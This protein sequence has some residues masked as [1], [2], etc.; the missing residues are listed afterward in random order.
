MRSIPDDM[1]PSAVAAIDARLDTLV[2]DQFISLPWA[3]ESGS[4]AWGFP[5]PDSDFDCRFVYVR[6]L[7]DYLAL[8]PKRDVI[9][10]LLT[11]ELDVN[12]WDVQKAIK[13]MLNGNAVIIEWLTSPIIYRGDAAFRDELLSLADR[14]LQRERV[15]SHYFHLALSMK[16]R[17]FADTE[18]IPLK[19]LFYVMR[20]AMALRWMR[21]NPS[22]RIA[23]MHFPTLMALSDLPKTIATMMAE[24]IERKA[25]TRELGS[26]HVPGEIRQFIEAEMAMANDLLSAETPPDSARIAIAQHAFRGILSRFG[27]A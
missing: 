1:K 7:D 13:L 17:A 27:P 21:I 11:D 18:L 2:A 20:P 5:S 23:P 25:T 4:R 10:T 14:V 12:G 3:I 19:K 16:K 24:L 22:E 15:A 26:G 9:E 6:R 8:F